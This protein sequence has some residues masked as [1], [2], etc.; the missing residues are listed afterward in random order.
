[1]I[2]QTYLR[3][4]LHKCVWIHLENRVG[5][6]FWS[7]SVRKPVAKIWICGSQ[8]PITLVHVIGNLLASCGSFSGSYNLKACLK[9][10]KHSDDVNKH[11]VCVNVRIYLY[12]CFWRCKSSENKLC[13]NN[14]NLSLYILQHNSDIQWKLSE[15]TN[16]Y[17]LVSQY[18]TEAFFENLRMEGYMQ[19]CVIFY[20]KLPNP[21]VY[22][23]FSESRNI[24]LSKKYN[25]SLSLWLVPVG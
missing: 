22:H 9:I 25:E 2:H 15:N 24:G 10:S 7:T 23:T 3:K 17:K 16:I 20:R 21:E 13:L 11:C 8:F 14:Y 19:T 12:K 5:D 4:V 1:M 18:Y 6:A